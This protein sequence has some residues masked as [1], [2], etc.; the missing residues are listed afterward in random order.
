L[1]NLAVGPIRIVRRHADGLI[2]VKE[3]RGT[4]EI[5]ARGIP[6]RVESRHGPD[7]TIQDWGVT[8]DELEPHYD[9]FEYLCGVS[10]K[11]GNIKGTIQ[12]GGN[13]FE[14]PRAREY[15]TP[16]MKEPYSERYF[17]R[18]PKV[19]DITLTRNPRPI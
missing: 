11:A 6:I 7:L 1:F 3:C 17:A 13:P 15:P 18:E 10:G 4:Q 9:R 5:A 8:Y 14:A 12:P 16:P 2:P 19:S